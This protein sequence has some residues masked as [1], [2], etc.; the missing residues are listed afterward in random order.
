MRNHAVFIAGG[1]MRFAGWAWSF[2]SASSREIK[3]FA[4]VSHDSSVFFRSKVRR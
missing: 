2:A 1:V 4:S 3:T